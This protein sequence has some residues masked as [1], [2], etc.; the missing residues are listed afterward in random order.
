MGFGELTAILVALC[1][2]ICS[3]YFEESGKKIGSINVNMTRLIFGLIFLMIFN[4]FRSGMILPFNASFEIIKFMG[5][6]GFIGMF[7]GDLLLYEAFILLSAR[8]TM[9]IFFLVPPITSLISFIFL[10]E[11]MNVIEIVGMI[12]ILVGIYIVVSKK[13]T[14]DKKELSKKG[15]ILAFGATILQASSNVISKYA[16]I[17]YDPFLSAQIR[18]IVSILGFGILY[19]LRGNWS[20][21]IK[22]FKEKD[23]MI[24]IGI[25]SFFGPFLGVSLT[26]LSLQFISA[27]IAAT[28]SSI[29]PIILIPYTFFI[30]KER[31]TR[32]DIIGTLIAFLGL[33]IIL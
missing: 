31:V 16:V 6:S 3:A 30:K 14:S 20:N 8:I 12:I 9:L 32:Y 17:D 4:L 33:I 27:G 5:F 25:G 21:Y 18:I 22:T 29:S 10:G 26:L 2:T 11:K 23:V 15:L 24:K 19:T 28:L 1:W 13:E 7:L